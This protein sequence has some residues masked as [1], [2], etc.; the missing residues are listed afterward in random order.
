VSTSGG[1]ETGETENSFLYKTDEVPTMGVLKEYIRAT[2]A[3]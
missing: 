1:E 2:V 3:S